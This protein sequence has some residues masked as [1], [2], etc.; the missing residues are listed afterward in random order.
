ME[1]GPGEECGV[2]SFFIKY[3]DY[4]GAGGLFE[5]GDDAVDEVFGDEGAV[6]EAEED[7]FGILRNIFEC[8]NQG[9]E[10]A[11]LII[12]VYDNACL[13]EV[14]GFLDGVGVC[15]E[16]DGDCVNVRGF[17]DGDDLLEEGSV[18]EFE[19]GFWLSH[20]L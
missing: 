20:S 16:D 4:D 11:F 1:E 7:G 10:L 19:E 14:D 17:E 6:D 18:F 15:S 5:S 12:F 2:A 3:R 9:G 13:R 8:G